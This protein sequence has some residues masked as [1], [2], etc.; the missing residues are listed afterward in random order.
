MIT[1][2]YILN[3]YLRTQLLL[4]YFPF[5]PYLGTYI[6]SVLTLLSYQFIMRKYFV[7]FMP[8]VINYQQV[9]ALFIVKPLVIQLSS[10][11]DDYWMNAIII[12]CKISHLCYLQT[13]CF[14]AYGFSILYMILFHTSVYYDGETMIYRYVVYNTIAFISWFVTKGNR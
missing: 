1:G 10:C 2:I 13:I 8:F 6:F 9:H 14:Y 4:F 11:N 3:Y 5:K 7:C 12:T